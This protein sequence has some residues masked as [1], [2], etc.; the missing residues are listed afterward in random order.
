MKEHN[1]PPDKD[2]KLWM[3]ARKRASFK[4]NLFSYIVINIFL[5]LLW[6]F[7]SDKQDHSGWPWPLWVTLGWGVG[8]AFHYFGAYVYPESNSVEKEYDKLKN[9]ENK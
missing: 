2:P 4:S 5:W 8:L 7:N 6:Y 9:K 3:I 1:T